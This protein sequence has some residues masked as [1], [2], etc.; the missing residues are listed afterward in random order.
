[1]LLAGQVMAGFGDVGRDHEDGCRE[2]G[3]VETDAA[4]VG[5]ERLRQVRA[6]PFAREGA[7]EPLVPCKGRRTVGGA[8]PLAS[9]APSAGLTMPMSVA[10]LE[11]TGPTWRGVCE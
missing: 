1:M 10:R 3:V 4:V 9:S 6:E 2:P 8:P 7:V 11:R 5:G